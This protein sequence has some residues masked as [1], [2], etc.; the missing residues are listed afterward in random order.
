MS[1]ITQEQLSHLKIFFK[2]DY[3]GKIKS[4]GYD[5]MLGTSIKQGGLVARIVPMTTD[6]DP[7][8]DDLL[9]RIREEILPKSYQGVSIYVTRDEIFKPLDQ[10][11]PI[12]FKNCSLLSHL[13]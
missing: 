3:K 1:E 10:N 11:K 12:K 4:L 9:I 6:Q 2:E 13:K 7:I 8:S 5:L